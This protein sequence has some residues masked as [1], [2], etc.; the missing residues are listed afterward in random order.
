MKNLHLLS[1][2]A[3][4]RQSPVSTTVKVGD[5]FGR[6]TPSQ[7]HVITIFNPFPK[8]NETTDYTD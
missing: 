3:S 5:C 1:L 6:F 7:R 2:R 8:L 4:A